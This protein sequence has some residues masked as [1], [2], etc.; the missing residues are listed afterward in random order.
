MESHCTTVASNVDVNAAPGNYDEALFGPA[1]LAAYLTVSE[2]AI[3]LDA[4][5][6]EFRESQVKHT[7]I[8]GHPEERMKRDMVDRSYSGGFGLL[9]LNKQEVI[10]AVIADF[11]MPR[12]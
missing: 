2:R 4:V 12:E 11:C 5:T 10:L 3:S 7:A 6:K 1:R 9:N 8:W